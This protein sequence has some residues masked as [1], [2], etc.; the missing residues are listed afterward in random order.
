MP[1]FCKAFGC[2][3]NCSSVKFIKYIPNIQLKEV[4]KLSL[5]QMESNNTIT[6]DAQGRLKLLHIHVPIY[7]RYP[8][9]GQ[10]H[11]C[12]VARTTGVFPERYTCTTNQ[13]Q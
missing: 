11:L 12:L 6:I 3:F 13:E 9:S 8:P 1:N 5:K 2:Y 10:L 4:T 7:E